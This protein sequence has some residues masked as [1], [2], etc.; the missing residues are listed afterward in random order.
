MGPDGQALE[1]A[2]EVELPT[3]SAPPLTTGLRPQV[4]RLPEHCANKVRA[5][6]VFD[7]CFPNKNLRSEY[8][9]TRQPFIPTQSL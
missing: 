1:G 4:P 5:T 8:E 3:S 9:G 2:G 7:G 6:A